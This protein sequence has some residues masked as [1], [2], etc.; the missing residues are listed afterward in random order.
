VRM[1]APLPHTWATAR[2]RPRR[3]LKRSHPAPSNYPTPL[4]FSRVTAGLRL[5]VP[6]LPE[7]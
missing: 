3:N 6:R 4:L 2:G 5:L 7:F 1:R